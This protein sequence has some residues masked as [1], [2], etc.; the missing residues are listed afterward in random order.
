MMQADFTA[1]LFARCRRLGIPTALDTCG[2]CPTEEIGKLDGL[3]D[4]VLFDLKLMDPEAHRKYVGVDNA[5][6]LRNL[7][8]FHGMGT[9]IFIRIPLIPGITDTEENLVATARYVRDLDPALHVDLL[10]Y[11]KYGT[12][13]YASLDRPYALPDAARQSAEKLNACKAI[14]DSR[15]LDC[16]LH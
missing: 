15:G 4:L 10:P 7:E 8:R 11:H 5:L 3:V 14:F 13:K 6:I 9:E 12:G 2:F 16:T 1:A